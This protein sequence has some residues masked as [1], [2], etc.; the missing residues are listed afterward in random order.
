MAATDCANSLCDGEILAGEKFCG[1][2]GYPVPV[3]QHPARWPGKELTEPDTELVAENAGEPFFEHAPPR[4]SP[5]LNNATRYLCAAAYLETGFANHVITNLL[6]TRKA[7]APSVHFDLGPIIRHCLRARKLLLIRNVVFVVCVLVGLFTSPLMTIDFLCLI[8][9]FGALVPAARRLPGKAMRKALNVFL[10]LFGLMLLG[11]LPVLLVFGAFAS[12]AVVGLLA[13]SVVSVAL[14]VAGALVA[15]AALIVATLTTEYIYLHVTFRTLIE[16]LRLGSPPPVQASQAMQA[17]IGIVDSAQWGN[18][19]FYGGED[20]FIGSGHQLDE[21]WSIA[22]KLEP[23][24]S[25]RRSP[26]AASRDGGQVIIDPV[27]LHKHIRERLLSLDDPNLPF[28][29]RVSALAVSDRLVGSGFL[30]WASPLVDERLRT[31]Y[32]YAS[33]EAVEALI[34]HPQAGL[35]YYQQVAVSDEGPWVTTRD[36]R[37]VLD[38]TDQG[39]AVSAFV[40]AAVEGHM[41][42]LQYVR[43]ALPPVKAAYRSIDLMP[44]V[45]NAKFRSV[46]LKTALRSFFRD[47]A[48]APAGII[49]EIGT[50]RMQRRV[51]KASVTPD[52]SVAGELGAEFSLREWG[53]ESDFDSYI[54]ELDVEKY[55]KI[56][57]RVLLEAVQDFLADNHVSVDAF[58]NSA[59]S[60]INGDFISIG[61]FAGDN[62]NL[63]SGGNAYGPSGQVYSPS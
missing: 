44:S 63:G 16:H 33:P 7:V 35:R 59:N 11:L 3:A 38:G 21:H 32:S 34:R 10:I 49:Q 5:P 53:A 39:I 1:E 47:I 41:F 54:E 13:G 25:S 22:I 42:Y 30:P 4:T 48:Y 23:A 52:G 51:E 60:I 28:N 20:P 12:I 6:A 55:D 58:S 29:E 8:F 46:I 9:V 24:H 37:E 14:N 62:N 2:C 57:V 26:L 56:I 31:P 17:R 36:G 19:T 43:T 50:R 15:V 40:Y 27:K 45:S 61:S 18:I